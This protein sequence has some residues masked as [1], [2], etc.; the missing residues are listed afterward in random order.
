MKKL[1]L[2]V[3]ILLAA[4]TLKAQEKIQWMD[5]EEAVAACSMNPKKIFVDVYTNWCGW[6]KKMDQTTF[7]DPA[8]IQYMNEHF[9]AVK[10]NAERTDPVRFDGQTY[11]YV[12]GPD[13]KRGVHQLAAAMLN[14]RMSYPSYVIFNEEVE[15]VQV[16]PG[17]QK[18]EGFLPILHFFGENA[19]LSET[20]NEFYTEYL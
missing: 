10:F 15:N 9:Y 2:T 13:G 20:L 6:C 8:V 12:T 1:I 16:V 17:Y 5:F 11:V 19:Y 14:N 3:A 18:P 7:S 4:T